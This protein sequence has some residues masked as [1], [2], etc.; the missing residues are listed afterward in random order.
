MRGQ[1]LRAL[2]DHRQVDL[3]LVAVAVPRL[4]ARAR[5]VPGTQLKI[6]AVARV[7]AVRPELVGPGLLH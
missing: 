5:L 6:G 2:V 7:Q 4:S 3:A 1:A